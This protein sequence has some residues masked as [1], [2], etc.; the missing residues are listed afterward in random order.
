MIIICGEGNGNVK[1][2]IDKNGCAYLSWADM[3]YPH[4]IA[5]SRI[6]A[7]NVTFGKSKMMEKT[8][9]T[10]VVRVGA[11]QF[12]H[13]GAPHNYFGFEHLLKLCWNPSLKCAYN[14]FFVVFNSDVKIKF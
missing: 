12:V 9:F 8:S 10:H 13:Q 14:I 11:A 3:S 7:I 1:G 4:S 2:F 6:A 5:S